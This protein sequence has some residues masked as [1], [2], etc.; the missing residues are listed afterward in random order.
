MAVHCW[1]HIRI[2]CSAII[3]SV[4][5]MQGLYYIKPFDFIV[6]SVFNIVLKWKFII[7]HPVQ[8]I[9]EIS[10]SLIVLSKYLLKDRIPCEPPPLERL[11]PKIPLKQHVILNNYMEYN[12]S[13]RMFALTEWNHCI[14]HI[15]S[16]S[17]FIHLCRQVISH[18]LPRSPSSSLSLSLSGMYL[19]D[20]NPNRY[21]KQEVCFIGELRIVHITMQFSTI[22]IFPDSWWLNRLFQITISGKCLIIRDEFCVNYLQYMKV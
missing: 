12:F 20:N 8:E 14:A 3:L 15:Y 9:F 5:E 7:S 21:R 19:L 18:L 17:I 22:G 11:I 2:C 16:L 4:A 13:F 6:E 1:F 10:S